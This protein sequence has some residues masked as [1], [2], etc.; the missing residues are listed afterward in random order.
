R[1]GAGLVA[2][3]RSSS[4]TTKSSG[5][6]L[7]FKEVRLAVAQLVQLAIVEAEIVAEFR[8]DGFLDALGH[9][10]AGPVVAL[11]RPLEDRDAIGL[12][13]GVVHAPLGLGDAFETPEK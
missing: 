7:I 9:R 1:E 3:N 10:R 2:S 8:K 12:L 13:E 5:R 11:H 4:V 6:C